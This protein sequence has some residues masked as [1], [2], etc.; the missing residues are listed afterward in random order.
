MSLP[1]RGLLQPS[2]PEESPVTISWPF[3]YI[4]IVVFHYLVLFLF[5]PLLESRTEI[6]FVLFIEVSLVLSVVAMID[7]IKC[8]LNGT[9]A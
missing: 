2:C 5:F 6:V 8:V 3:V 4:L 7:T 9:E 1:Q